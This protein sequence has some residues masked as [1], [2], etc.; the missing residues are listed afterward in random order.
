MP[1]LS[2]EECVECVESPPFGV[3]VLTEMVDEVEV[4]VGLAFSVPVL[5]PAV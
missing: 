5:L 2:E 4:P 3:W 1:S